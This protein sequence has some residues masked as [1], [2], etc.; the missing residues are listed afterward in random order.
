MNPISQHGART[1]R[2]TDETIWLFIKTL[3]VILVLWSMGSILMSF[4][5][6]V[7]G[8][9]FDLKAF[10]TEIDKGCSVGHQRDSLQYTFESGPA[11]VAVTGTG[12]YRMTLDNGRVVTAEA[13]ACKEVEMLNS[14]ME[15]PRDGKVL[16]KLEYTGDKS[17]T[18]VPGCGDNVCGSGESYDICPQDCLTHAS[19]DNPQGMYPRNG[20]WWLVGSGT[21]ESKIFQYRQDWS[22]TGTSYD[23]TSADSR[24]R[25]IHQADSGDWWMT[26]FGEYGMNRQGGGSQVSATYL[27]G[28]SPDDSVE[29]MVDLRDNVDQA[30][31]LF[32]GQNGKWYVADGSGSVHQYSGSWTLET[33]HDVS[34]QESNPQGIYQDSSGAWWVVGDNADTVFKYSQDWSYTGTSYDISQQTMLATDLHKRNGQW[35]LVGLSTNPNNFDDDRPAVFVYD[36][37]WNFQNRIPLHDVSGG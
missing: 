19:I 34:S 7:A 26:G 32:Q 23:L 28:G 12:T 9:E 31:S 30:T 5:G 20:G 33:S 14:P 22:Y 16:M 27:L 6:Q 21:G 1:G 17:V 15:V 29:N 11:E 36:S 4:E 24:M 25:D 35:Y 13:Q 18:I 3:A 8:A 10:R 37:N 2:T